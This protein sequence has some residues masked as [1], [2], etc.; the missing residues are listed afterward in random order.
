MTQTVHGGALLLV[1]GM[2]DVRFWR[3]RRHDTCQLVDGEGKG[4]VVG[5][6]CRLDAED[7][8]GVLGVVDDDFDSLMGISHSTRNLVATDAHDLECLLCRSPAL[9]KVLSEFGDD[10]KIREFEETMGVDVRGGLLE[11]T[12]VFGRLRLAAKRGD[13]DIDVGTMRVPQFIDIDTWTVDGPRLACAVS[14]G[15]SPH[16]WDGLERLLEELPAADPWRVAHGHDMV[17]ILRIGLMRKL[18]ALP[19]NKGAKDIARILRVAISQEELERTTLWAD[20]R[21]WEGTNG[22]RILP[23]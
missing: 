20:V 5:A 10:S 15:A 7:V 4:N 12:I 2:D 17:Q 14:R 18:G 1:E 23:S 19:T 9:D 13:L 8:H 11:R 16:D 21:A 3:T 6:I 22:Y